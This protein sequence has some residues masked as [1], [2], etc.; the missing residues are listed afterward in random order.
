MDIEKTILK[1]IF[2]CNKEYNLFNKTERIIISLSGGKD[3]IS[4]L[5]LLTKIHSPSLIYPIHIYP[6]K[7]D[8][9]LSYIKNFSENT[10]SMANPVKFLKNPLYK[11]DLLS[12]YECA[13]G[14]R[15][16]VFEEAD[17]QK[18]YKIALGHTKNDVSETF[19][20]NVIY[21]GNK[22]TIKPFQTFFD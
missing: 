4:L 18:I 21:S 5:K 20:M 12:C 13:R 9:V 7:D 22:D 3:S 8:K 15:K 10:L 19:L 2:K 16:T 17:K 6:Y 11:K 14:R 1:K